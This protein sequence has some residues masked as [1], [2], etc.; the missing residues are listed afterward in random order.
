MRI[1]RDASVW[2]MRHVYG[3]RKEPQT[4]LP[5]LMYHSVSNAMEHGVNAYYRVVT[6]PE[7]FREQM[8]W[9]K[10]AGYDAVDLPSAASLIDRPQAR[11]TPTVCLTF[12]DGFLDFAIE[13]WP[14]LREHGFGATVFL[15][16]GYIGNGR[17]SF[18][19]RQC[20]TWAEVRELKTQG[21]DFGSHTVS[22]PV[23]HG[24]SWD[25]IREE[26]RA[27][28]VAIEQEVSEPI[29]TFAYPYAYPQE[30]RSFTGRLRDELREAGYDWVVTTVVG[31]ARPDHDRLALPRLP[32]N[33]EDD[34]SLLMSKVGGAYEWV[35]DVQRGA[36]QVRRLVRV[37]NAAAAA[38]RALG[39]RRY[40]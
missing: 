34:R 21:C 39:R 11:T 6:P 1:D 5:I 35:G 2:L 38:V 36:R 9:L 28:K 10:E 13:A 3:R 26:L 14:V 30:D 16:T 19:G 24:L 20:L 15:P 8:A 25:R 29:S 40:R 31:S 18:K 32:V 17:Q 7:R 22:H 4:S 12:D 37:T 23:L 33:G 27:S